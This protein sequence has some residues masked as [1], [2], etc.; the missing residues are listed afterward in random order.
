VAVEV[1]FLA[2]GVLSGG[3][4]GLA[5]VAFV[6]VVGPFVEPMIWANRRYL[7]LPD[8]GLHPAMQSAAEV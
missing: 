6:L 8:H 1:G 2:G 5:T 4:I 7:H 3:P